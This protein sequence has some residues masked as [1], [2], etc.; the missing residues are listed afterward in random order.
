MLQKSSKMASKPQ[1]GKIF[2]VIPVVNNFIGPPMRWEY[3][4][5]GANTLVKLQ[6][7]S[8]LLHGSGIRDCYKVYGISPQ[9]TLNLNTFRRKKIQ[10]SPQQKYYERIE[11]DKMFSFVSKKRKSLDILCLCARNKRNFSSNNG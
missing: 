2:Y 5:Q 6:V 11:I 3:F 1:G 7:K 9:T 4:Y 10:I 8:S